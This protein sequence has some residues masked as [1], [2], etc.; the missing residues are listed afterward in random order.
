[1]G[2]ILVSANDMEIGGIQKSLI[3]FVEYLV[4]LGHDIDLVLWQK[5]GVLRNKIPTSVN[6]IEIEPSTTW[7]NIGKEKNVFKKIYLFISYLKFKF[8][9]LIIK[10]A[11]LFFPKIRKKYDVAV[12][13]SQNGFPRFYIIDNVAA[14]M[15]YLWYHHGSYDSFGAAHELDKKYYSEFNQVVTVSDSNKEMLQK[16]F[17]A[18]TDKIVVIPNIINIDE[19]IRLAE[20]DVQDFRRTEGYFNLVTVA[21]FSKEKG[22]DLSIDIA[23]VLRERGLKF[24]WYFIGDGSS[25]LQIKEKIK[26]QNLE[27]FCILLGSKENPYPYM[28]HAD[29][30]IQ[31]SYVESQSI[32]VYEALVLKKI[33]VATNLPALNEALQKGKLGVLCTPATSSFVEAILLLLNDSIGRQKIVTAVENYTVQ[34]ERA[35]KQITELF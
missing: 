33:I 29:L 35:Y 20:D 6:I 1:M 27:D 22:I 4:S 18:I 31:T 34:N 19:V 9:A 10:K 16:Y 7:K 32:T 21:R 2:K 11:W 17:S 24:K 3:V 23:I 15:K 8:Y 26:K 28:K 13:Y 5:G 14:D 12:C 25:F 30:Y